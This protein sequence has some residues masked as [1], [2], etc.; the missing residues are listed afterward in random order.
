MNIQFDSIKTITMN[1]FK[2]INDFN[3]ITRLADLIE[4]DILFIQ[5]DS[6]KAITMKD[7]QLI[8]DFHS[9]KYNENFYMN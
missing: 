2:W 8:N 6:I 3:F 5:F 7:F 4:M 1:D 9:N